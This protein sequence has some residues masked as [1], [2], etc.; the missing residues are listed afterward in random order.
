MV[1]PGTTNVQPTQLITARQDRLRQY[2]NPL[3]MIRRLW[4]QRELIGQFTK[5]N[6]LQRY[7]GSYLGLLW[8]FATPL[9]LLLVYTFVF[10][11]VFK[12]RWPGMKTG[13]H[14]QFALALFAGL[15][16]FNIFSE[17]TLAAP[18]LIVGNP[19][20]V[21]KVVFPLEI[22]PVSALGAAVVN[23]LF[24]LLILFVGAIAVQGGI[25]W[26]VIFLPLMYLPLLL[27]CLGLA[28]FFASLGVFIRDIGHLLGVAVQMLF[29]LTPIFYPLEAIPFPY[30]YMIY[31][32]PL[33]FIVNHFRR[34]ALFGQMPDWA[35]FGVMTLL[36]GL[37]CL[38]GYIWFM[39]SKKTFADVV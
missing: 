2:A 22:L 4:Q 21:K 30:R 39:K 11:I 10:S 17:T 14:A 7:K 31:A 27:L 3:T 33:T 32:N 29:F 12:A 20:Y 28:W 13:G 26:T 37:V 23:S 9:A 38:A 34:V 19:N 35:E 18:Q 36:A 1:R 6:V 8:S 16:A 5:R 24:S 25:P 15:V